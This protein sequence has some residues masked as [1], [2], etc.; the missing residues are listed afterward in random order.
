[1][2]FDNRIINDMDQNSGEN[3]QANSLSEE[4]EIVPTTDESVEINSVEEMR[5]AFSKIREEVE[6]SSTSVDLIVLYREAGGLIKLMDTPPFIEKAGDKLDEIRRVA[7]EEFAQTARELN[8]RV[9]EVNSR[10]H[11]AE[12]WGD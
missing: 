5:E 8:R 1:M 7:E 4:A 2:V 10:S 11:F 12:K 3:F 6:N 9:P